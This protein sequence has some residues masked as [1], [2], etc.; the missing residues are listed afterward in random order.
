MRWEKG[1]GGKKERD[2][3]GGGGA[4]WVIGN[5]RGVRCGRG[6]PALGVG[7]VDEKSW[8]LGTL[9][10]GEWGVSRGVSQ[11][12]CTKL[13]LLLMNMGHGTSEKRRRREDKREV[14][15]AGALG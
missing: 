15:W 2:G 10:E 1:L 6:R 9:G 12:P 13:Y 4:W 5:G 8:V 14:G 3:G 7:G 11:V